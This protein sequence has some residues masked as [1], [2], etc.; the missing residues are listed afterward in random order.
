MGKIE[1][2]N[3]GKK[4]FRFRVEQPFKNTCKDCI[5]NAWHIPMEDRIKYANSKLPLEKSQL[6]KFLGKKA[7]NPKREPNGAAKLKNSKSNIDL[8]INMNLTDK[9]LE[10]IKACADMD[11]KLRYAFYHRIE[12]TEPENEWLKF[13]KNW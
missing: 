9:E 11:D 8:E 1:C 6:F 10:M 2:L 7:Q 3:C 5:M 4:F 12:A 13:L